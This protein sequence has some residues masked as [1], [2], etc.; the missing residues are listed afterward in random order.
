MAVTCTSLDVSKIRTDGGTQIRAELNQSRVEELAELLREG[1]T[2]KDS[3][4]VFY[5]GTDYW[6]G[7]GFHRVEATKLASIGIDNAEIRSAMSGIDAEIRSGT[8]EDAIEY[9]CGANADHGLPRKSQDKRNAVTRLVTLPK[10]KNRT[11][12]EIAKQC[13]VT[14]QYVSKILKELNYN[15]C[16]SPTNQ[17]VEPSE[18][19]EEM[20]ISAPT[21]EEKRQKVEEFFRDFP[22]SQELSNREI[23][24]RCE[25][26][27]G[28][29]RKIKK[30]LEE[31][32][33]A[34]QEASAAITEPLAE[35]EPSQPAIEPM[36]NMPI[37]ESAQPDSEG[38]VSNR[39][40]Q[41]GEP[42]VEPEPPQSETEP[43]C[44]MPIAEEPEPISEP[45]ASIV[46]PEIVSEPEPISVLFETRVEEESVMVVDP[47]PEIEPVSEPWITLVVEAE[48]TQTEEPVAVP[49]P[50][51]ISGMIAPSEEV[52][53]EREIR[54]L[55]VQERNEQ[56][57]EKGAELPTG[58]YA[59]LVVDPPWPMKK[60]ER[61]VRPNQVE[62]D[63]PTM[64][65]EQLRD[66][67]L[68]S[69]AGDDCHLYLWTTQKY[70]PMALRLAEHWG[71]KYQCLMTWVKN[72][73]PTPFSWMYTTEHVLFCS[74]G[75]L[76]LLAIGRRLDFVAKGRE[77]SR[78]PDVFYNLVKDVSPEPRI[79]VF[80]RERRDGFEQYGYEV[81]KY[82]PA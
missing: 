8:R 63:Y 2:F 58:K 44:E 82:V 74:K 36:N 76:P 22:G 81:E 50:I 20:R 33:R 67:E 35:P 30:E 54:R 79:D 15:S 62:F 10:W 34:E 3:V 56:L 78:K 6:L 75:N 1:H 19:V 27:E 31:K 39:G 55:Q 5:D 16:N 43:L 64:N 60:I 25:V 80:S 37:A 45:V 32:Q 21:N 28:F 23:A 47:E 9:A 17:P 12:E 7:D 68:P 24:R 53:R 70:L 65:E 49:D 26:D 77:H 29:I 42:E 72:V 38:S 18:V 4:V 13:G 59:C 48:Q 71:F 69:L 52:L 11:Q 41:S 57:R 14:Q 61:E 51:T 66:F 40:F 73:G 46:E